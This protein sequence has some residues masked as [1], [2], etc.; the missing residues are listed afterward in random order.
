MDSL[1]FSG[2]HLRKRVI[3]I[4][5]FLKSSLFIVEVIN[6]SFELQLPI[7]VSLRF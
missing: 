5:V 7:H 3:S 1:L 4:V 2:C 6:Y